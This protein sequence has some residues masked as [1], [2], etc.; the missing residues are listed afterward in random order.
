MRS[1]LQQ[2]LVRRS[3]IMTIDRWI[4]FAVAAALAGA[5]AAGAAELPAQS[6]KPKRAESVQHC[7]V[8]GSPGVLAANGICVRI[9]GSISARVSARQLK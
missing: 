8:A 2:T 7:D 5:T 1:V 3:S 6:K 4:S 9:S